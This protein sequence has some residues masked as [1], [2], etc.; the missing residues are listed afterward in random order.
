MAMTPLPALDRTSATFKADVDAFFGTRLPTFTTE[1]N[2]L[3]TDVTNKQVTA[4]DAATTATT[5]A[6]EALNSANNAATSK[7]GA[8]SARDAAVVAK[9]AAEAALDSFD[10]RYLGA[11]A[12]APTADNDGAALL[13]G[14]LYWDTALPGM[15]SWNG[16]AWVTLPA[17]T[18]AAISNTPAGSIAATTV[19]DALN[20]LDTEKVATTAVIAIA[21]GGT[22]ATTANAA[23]DAIGA[24]RK[25]TILGTVSQSAGVPTGA[26]IER[27]SNANGDYVRFADGTQICTISSTFTSAAEVV[28]SYPAIFVAAPTYLSASVNH[29]PNPR[30]YL[31]DTATT[32]DNISATIYRSVRETRA[33]VVDTFQVGCMAI[34]RWF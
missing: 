2:A 17:A 27:G 12:T 7:T 5:K 16:T 6:S 34:G 31:V 1:A 33:P 18:A 4:S 28:W 20:E 19:Q 23:A 32:G 10:D 21:N 15:R 8:D 9:N 26:V 3:Q 11:K 22:G 13:T 29:P 30:Y 14:A 25:G 24:Y